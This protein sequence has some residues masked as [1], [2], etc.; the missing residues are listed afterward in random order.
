MSQRC[1]ERQQVVVMSGLMSR[2]CFFLFFSCYKLVKRAAEHGILILPNTSTSSVRVYFMHNETLSL[3][4][5]SFS[6]VSFKLPS[7]FKQHPEHQTR[8]DVLDNFYNLINECTC[9]IRCNPAFMWLELR[10]EVMVFF[11]N[12]FF[13]RR[14]LFLLTFKVC[15]RTNCLVFFHFQT[16]SNVLF[17]HILKLIFSNDQCDKLL[18]SSTNNVCTPVK[19]IVLTINH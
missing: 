9:D 12:S 7:K 18:V 1:D 11:F 4:I 13:L 19:P 6:I 3:F 2:T 16:G 5:S 14:E 10:W 15:C 17:T 8:D